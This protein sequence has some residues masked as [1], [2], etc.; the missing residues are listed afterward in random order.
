MSPGLHGGTGRRARFEDDDVEPPFE[1]L[2]GG[3]EPDGAGADDGDG[4]PGEAV[5]RGAAGRRGSREGKFRDGHACAPW[6]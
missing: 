2:C 6:G 4:Q 5:E 1:E 3:G